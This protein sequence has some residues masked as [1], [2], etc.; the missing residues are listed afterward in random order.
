MVRC[1]EVSDT[2]PSPISVRLSSSSLPGLILGRASSG[3]AAAESAE[4]DAARM[5]V[6]RRETAARLA[7]RAAAFAASRAAEAEEIRARIREH[8]GLTAR[9]VHVL[10]ECKC[11]CTLGVSSWTEYMCTWVQ[12]V[13]II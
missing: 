6:M 8:E 2:N 13:G 5:A 12:N 4:E 7:R 11:T 1:E 9:A 3:A 10:R